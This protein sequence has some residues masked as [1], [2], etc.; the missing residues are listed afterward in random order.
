MYS[1]S[2]LIACVLAVAVARSELQNKPFTTEEE[3]YYDQLMEDVSTNERNWK[4]C[5]WAN[6]GSSKQNGEI[7]IEINGLIDV[8]FNIGKCPHYGRNAN[9]NTGWISSTRIYIEEMNEPQPKQ[10]W[11]NDAA[12]I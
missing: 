12:L 11:E 7:K 9:G 4:E 1:T 6:F 10:V 2:V 8:S 5:A 3:A